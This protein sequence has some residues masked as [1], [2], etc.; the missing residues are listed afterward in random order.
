MRM[1][2]ELQRT[3]ILG[4]APSIDLLQDIKI[5]PKRCIYQY[6]RRPVRVM[7]QPNAVPSMAPTNNAWLLIIDNLDDISVIE[8]LLLRMGL[9]TQCPT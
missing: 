8:S 2:S 4:R 6:Q 3:G 1:P 5:L 9:R 7:V